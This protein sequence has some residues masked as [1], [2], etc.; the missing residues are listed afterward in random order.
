ML[1]P[2]PVH[3]SRIPR[4]LEHFFVWTV[5]GLA[6]FLVWRL[7][8]M[9][10]TTRDVTLAL[11]A[12]MLGYV[13]ADFV[14]GL[15]HWAFDRMGSEDTPVLGHAFIHPFRYH[16][17]DPKDMMSGDFISTN[18]KNSVGCVPILV[19]GLFIPT[20]PGNGW[21]VFGLSTLVSFVLAVW[22]TNQF[23][24]WAHLDAPGPVIRTL[25]RLH[26]VLTPEHH[27]DHHQAPFKANYCIT[28]GW[29]NPLLER[30]RFFHRLEAGLGAMGVRFN[31]G[32]DD[33]PQ[34]RSS[35]VGSDHGSVR[36]RS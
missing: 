2:V 11:A 13:V 10:V 34:S 20:A 12:A 35:V 36:Q 25:Q 23:H 18:G 24:K 15:I 26:L 14:S 9:L 4:P 8:G 17:V 29:C 22:M 33:D 30:L 21:A 28:S 6:A 32:D 1:R 31:D 19:A 3:G 7:V 27:D 16:H 5:L